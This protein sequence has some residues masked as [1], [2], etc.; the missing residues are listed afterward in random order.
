MINLA[1]IWCRIFHRRHWEY[2]SYWTG[3]GEKDW[4]YDCGKCGLKHYRS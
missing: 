2:F 1:A 4:G 3:F